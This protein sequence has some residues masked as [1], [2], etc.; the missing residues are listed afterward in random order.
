[1]IHGHPHWAAAARKLEIGFAGNLFVEF[2]GFLQGQ[3]VSKDG[4]FQ[5]ACKAQALEAVR[6]LSRS[7]VRP[8]LAGYGR[9]YECINSP[10]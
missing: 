8:E 2:Q 3:N 9:S 4:Y 5:H 6:S 1:M 7:D 10:L